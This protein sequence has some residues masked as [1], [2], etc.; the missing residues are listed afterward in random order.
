MKELILYLRLYCLFLQHG[1]YHFIRDTHGA[2]RD[3]HFA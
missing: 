2:G 1:A 3:W